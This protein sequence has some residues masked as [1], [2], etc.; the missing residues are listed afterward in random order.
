MNS[1]LQQNILFG[2]IK[3]EKYRE[4]IDWQVKWLRFTWV[5]FWYTA[6]KMA[7]F[8][9]VLSMQRYLVSEVNYALDPLRWYFHE[10]QEKWNSSL[11]FILV[12]TFFFVVFFVFFYYYYYL[13]NFD[14]NL[15]NKRRRKLIMRHVWLLRST[16]VTM[17]WCQSNVMSANQL[18]HLSMT[19]LT[20]NVAW[21][22]V[23]T[24]SL[25]IRFIQGNCW[26][27]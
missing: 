13:W 24:S 3:Y 27:V 4:H 18:L 25:Q 12:F 8:E 10:P 2:E 11:I 14:L 21:T 1:F 6:R 23:W 5:L 22:G 9:E 16:A 19:S 7:H 26:R 17:T 20:R 15:A